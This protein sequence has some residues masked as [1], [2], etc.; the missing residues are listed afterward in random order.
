MVI[1]AVLMNQVSS[2][3]I[4]C[5]FHLL[6][7]RLR[8]PVRCLPVGRCDSGRQ[9]PCQ[10]PVSLILLGSIGNDANRHECA[11]AWYGVFHAGR[12]EGLKIGR[13]RPVVR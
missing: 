11:D 3:Q 13:D 7:T 4:S 10:S 5:G 12:K 6:Q 2:F 9:K 1:Q 8:V